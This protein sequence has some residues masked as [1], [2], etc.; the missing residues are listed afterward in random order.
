MHA[1]VVAEQSTV[2]VTAVWRPRRT[3][4]LCAVAVVERSTARATVAWRPRRTMGYHAAIIVVAAL[5][6]RALANMITPVHDGGPEH[7]HHGS[8]A[9][10]SKSRL[11]RIAS[12]LY[13]CWRWCLAAPSAG[14]RTRS[15]VRGAVERFG[16][17]WRGE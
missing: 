1:A 5:G 15:H 12:V 17:R 11:A 14:A 7:R 10:T 4:E 16:C 2:R 8:M 6:V 13:P 9:S 3:S